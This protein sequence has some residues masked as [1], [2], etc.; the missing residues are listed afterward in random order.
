MFTAINNELRRDVKYHSVKKN[1]LLRNA[2][3]D[4]IIIVKLVS[5]KP[6]RI[7]KVVT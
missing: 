3:N 1:T 6:T 4:F 2:L 7:D 5:D